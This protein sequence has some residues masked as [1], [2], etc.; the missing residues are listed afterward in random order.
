[1]RRLTSPDDFLR[2]VW[3]ACTT[4]FLQQH[5]I[6]RQPDSPLLIRRRQLAPED[7]GDDAEHAAAVEK[8]GAGTE[9]APAVAGVRRSRVRSA[10]RLWNGRPRHPGDSSPPPAGGRS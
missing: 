10:R 3:K 2:T 5:A 7:A 9:E 6:V 8:Q 4:I 1:M